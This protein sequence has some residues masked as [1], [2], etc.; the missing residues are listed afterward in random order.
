MNQ[1]EPQ[2]LATQKVHYP[3]SG[4]YSLLLLK[5]LGSS[6]PSALLTSEHIACLLGKGQ[7]PL[8]PPLSLV[9]NSQSWQL[10]YTGVP[11]AAITVAL[12]T[13]QLFQSKVLN[14]FHSLPQKNMVRSVTAMPHSL[15][16][17]SVPVWFSIAMRNTMAKSSVGE[18]GLFHPT[19]YSPPRRKVRVGAQ[20]RNP[21][22]TLSV[23]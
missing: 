13:W 1:S 7:L 20:G 23:C 22:A 3:T 17:L 19:A 10:E 18:K 16:P 8:H 12:S 9:V 6:E 15:I 4:A 5:A 11:T 21:E 2:N 14:S